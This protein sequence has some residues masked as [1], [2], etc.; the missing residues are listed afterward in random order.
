[1]AQDLSEQLNRIGHKAELLITRYETLRAENRELRNQVERLNVEL[2]KKRQQIEQLEVEVEHFRISSTFAPDSK[3]AS[4]AR[5]II[6]QIV[7][8]IDACVADLMKDV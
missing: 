6:T 5:D 4:Q 3:S 2:V 1:M 8:E 7:R